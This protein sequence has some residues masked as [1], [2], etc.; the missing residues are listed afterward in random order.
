[1][2][3]AWLLACLA[4]MVSLGWA[5][6]PAWADELDQPVLDLE[7]LVKE[8]TSQNPEIQAASKKWEA[9]NEK[10]AQAGALDD[11]MLSLGIVNVPSS[12]NLRAEDMTMKEV[13][14][15]QKLPFPGKRALMSEMALKEAQAA[16]EGIAEKTQ[17][18]A[19]E[20]KGA[21]QDLSHVHR[22]LEVAQRNKDVLESL[23]KI[24]E[25]RY[26]LGQAAQTDLLKAQVEVSKMTDEIIM[27]GERKK[28]VEARLNALLA[29][30]TGAPLGRPAQP[31]GR[32][33]GVGLEYLRQAALDNNPT[34]RSMR[35]M[36]QAKATAQ[37]L[38]KAD[39]YPD[40]TLRFAYGQRDNGEDVERKDMLTGMVEINLPIWREAKLER[41]QAETKADTAA[42]EAQWEAMRNE[43][44][45][46][47]AETHAMLSRGERQI[48]LYQGGIIPQARLQVDSNLRTYAGGRAEFMALLDSQMALYKFELDYHLALTEYEKNLAVLEALLGRP[49]P[50]R[51][52]DQ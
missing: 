49:L 29:R 36:V 15:S 27:L 44:L 22:A 10:P 45:Y 40:F 26:S 28:A 30:P 41:K 20:V 1:M 38:A 43:I 48:E 21:Y 2:K 3:P 5:G 6:A 46:M 23:V 4:L 32:R 24:V 9:L 51:G 42:A 52:E 16:H 50:A 37:E 39:Y 47:I 14:I 18:V 17:R 12:L 35:R 13:G 7:A 33:L 19:R 8:A 25:S 34:L 31:L 11:P